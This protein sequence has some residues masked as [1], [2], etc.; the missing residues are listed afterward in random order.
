MSTTDQ[1]DLFAKWEAR[2]EAEGLGDLGDRVHPW[3]DG[4]LLG[5][6]APWNIERA[7][8]AVKYTP[9]DYQ[10]VLALDDLVYWLPEPDQEG[11]DRL[12]S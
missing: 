4:A 8:E 12:V 10:E 6:L 5:S 9:P 1:L 2:L 3:V 11:V 7:T